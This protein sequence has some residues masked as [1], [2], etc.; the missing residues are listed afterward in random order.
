MIG[1][2]NRNISNDPCALKLLSASM[3]IIWITK[4]VHVSSN[5][6]FILESRIIVIG[7]PI[8][9]EFRIQRE[10]SNNDKENI[11]VVFCVGVYALISTCHCFNLSVY[12]GGFTAISP[13]HPR[14]LAVIDCFILEGIRNCSLLRKGSPIL[15]LGH[16]GDCRNP[17]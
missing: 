12:E 6:N 9:N 5:E 14:L 11:Y 16:R 8:K 15:F 1:C 10:H 13:T 17:R 3:K 7:N 2:L 4:L